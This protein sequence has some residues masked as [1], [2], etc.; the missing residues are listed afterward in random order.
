MCRV[1]WRVPAVPVRSGIN[2]T[3][4]RHLGDVRTHVRTRQNREEEEDD[5]EEEE[6]P[7]FSERPPPQVTDPSSA[8]LEPFQKYL[9][10]PN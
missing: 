9:M 5:D 2:L 7:G 4:K 1:A 6:G 3:L 8:Y 10:E